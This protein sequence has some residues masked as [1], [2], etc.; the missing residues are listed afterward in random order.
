MDQFACSC[1]CTCTQLKYKLTFCFCMLPANPRRTFK[2]THTTMNR[3]KS[4]KVKPSVAGNRALRAH[5]RDAERKK[6]RDETFTRHRNLSAMSPLRE[7]RVNVKVVGKAYFI[8]K[9][10][11]LRLPG[12][13]YFYLP[14]LF[15]LGKRI[16]STN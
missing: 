10:F 16:L 9:Q 7:N 11:F 8:T 13:P 5:N 6:M 4:V 1:P 3:Q 2:S 14:N 12:R 15:F